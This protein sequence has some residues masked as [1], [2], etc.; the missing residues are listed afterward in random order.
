METKY[1]VSVHFATASAPRIVGRFNDEVLALRE[2]RAYLSDA[3][4][5]LVYYPDGT[6][7]NAKTNTR[8]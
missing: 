8:S 7:F 5:V 4:E 2:A 6:T 1:S 3:R